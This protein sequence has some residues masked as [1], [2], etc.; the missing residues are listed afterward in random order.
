MSERTS[1]T[2]NQAS[3]E[4]QDKPSPA[5]GLGPGDPGYRRIMIAAA[6]AGLAS[7]NAMYLTQEIGRAHV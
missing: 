4:A 2:Q 7:F 1:E 6:A 3:D 5:T